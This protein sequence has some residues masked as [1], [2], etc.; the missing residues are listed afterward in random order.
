MLKVKNENFV[1]SENCSKF[2]RSFGHF[3]ISWR[4][5]DHCGSFEVSEMSVYARS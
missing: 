4:S 3:V 2:T 5:H 1:K